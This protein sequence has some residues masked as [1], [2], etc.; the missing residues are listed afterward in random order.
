MD[1]HIKRELKQ[2]RKVPESE[3]DLNYKIF[4]PIIQNWWQNCNYFLKNTNYEE[5]SPLLKTSEEVRTALIE[6]IPD[7]RTSKLD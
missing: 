4:L 2:I 7:Q 1:C 6:K 5:N 3:L